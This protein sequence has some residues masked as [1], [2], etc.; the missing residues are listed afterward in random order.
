MCSSAVHLPWTDRAPVTTAAARITSSRQ[1]AA[2]SRIARCA[3]SEGRT[4]SQR[5]G[6]QGCLPVPPARGVG[7]E[8]SRPPLTGTRRARGRGP[9]VDIGGAVTGTAELPPPAE[10]PVQPVRAGGDASTGSSPCSP[11][12]KKTRTV[13]EPPSFMDVEPLPQREPRPGVRKNQFPTTRWKTRQRLMCGRE[14]GRL[15]NSL[16]PLTRPIAS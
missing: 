14:R 15:S 10:V 5:P 9:D 12:G 3:R 8:R 13:E 1:G 11:P 7:L 4:A 16:P 2:R 6:M